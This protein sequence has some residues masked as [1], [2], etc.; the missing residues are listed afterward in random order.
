MAGCGY[1]CPKCEGK[2]LE[3]DLSPCSWCESPNNEKHQISDEEWMKAV[4]EGPCCSDFGTQ[5]NTDFFDK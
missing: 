5:Q 1:V 2:G 3:E 4:H